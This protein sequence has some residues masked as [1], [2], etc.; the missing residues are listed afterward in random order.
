M[1]DKVT[2]NLGRCNKSICKLFSKI[3]N[4]NIPYLGVLTGPMSTTVVTRAAVHLSFLVGP[5]KGS[6]IY[7]FCSFRP[8]RYILRV[9]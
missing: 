2:E 7:L 8:L 4:S 1:K 3:K 5:N 6:L 9:N